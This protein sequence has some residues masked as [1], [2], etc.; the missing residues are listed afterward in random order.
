MNSI[1]RLSVSLRAPLTALGLAAAALAF[2]ATGCVDPQGRFDEFADRVPDAAPL[3]Q[4]DGADLGG[5]PDMNGSFLVAVVPVVAPDIT[6]QL[7]WDVTLEH[8]ADGTGVLEVNSTAVSTK[9]NGRMR[10]GKTTTLSNIPVNKAGEFM[11]PFDD[12]DLPGT[13][14][15]LTGNPLKLDAFL[16]ATIKSANT[17]CGT[18]GAG[19]AVLTPLIDITNSAFGAVRVTKDAQGTDLPPPMTSCVAANDGDAGPTDGDAG[20][21]DGGSQA[22][23]P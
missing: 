19:S 21:P 12:L 22:P 16:V 6:V 14:N 5:L 13:A 7:Y 15:E 10:V 1:A 2:A 11:V 9:G 23:K 18:L 8:K 20:L 4:P 3:A 17:F